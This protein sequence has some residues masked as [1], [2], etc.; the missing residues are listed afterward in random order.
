MRIVTRLALM[1]VLLFVAAAYIEAGELTVTNFIDYGAPTRVGEKRGALT[2]YDV[3]QS[4]LLVMLVQDFYKNGVRVSVLLVN[5]DTGKTE[6]YWFPN[7]ETPSGDP[8]SLLI[9]SKNRLYFTP[10]STL[11]EF[12]IPTR[13]FTYSGPMPGTAMS[14]TEAEDGTIFIA[15]YPT[16][17]LV[18]FDPDTQTIVRYGRLDPKE[19]YPYSMAIDDKGWIYSGLGTTR[20]NLVAFNIH[21]GTL[22]QLA[23]ESE[24]STGHGHVKVGKNN[25]IY[26][27]GSDSGL[28]YEL[29][30]GEKVKPAYV[31]PQTKENTLKWSEVATSW[32][33]GTRLLAL[34][35]MD[36]WA[37][38]MEPRTI[39]K[40]IDFAYDAE[41]GRITSIVA[42]PDGKIYGNTAHPMRFFMFDPETNALED[43]GS[44]PGVGNFPEFVVQDK[45]IVGGS[46][47]NGALYVYDTEKT[48]NLNQG[49]PKTV[50]S[51][52]KDIARPRA[53]VAHTDGEHIVLGG[54][55]GYGLTGGGLGIYNIN[56]G[57]S[58]LITHDNLIPYQST[59]GLRVLPS[60]DVVGVTSIK[61]PGGGYVYAEQAELYILDWETRTVSFSIKPLER[62]AFGRAVPGPGEI[63][64]LEV[65]PDGLVYGIGENGYLFV[66]DPV[67]KEIIHRRS[68][69]EYGAP[70]QR[71]TL[72]LGPDAHVYALMQ[73]ALIH[74]NPQTF[75]PTKVADLPVPATATPYL[76]GNRLYFASQTHLWSCDFVQR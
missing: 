38:V 51:Y 76:V 67:K 41:G 22:R 3:D 70:M 36:K 25:V 16:A 47:A 40:R 46:Y 26:G 49:H 69:S 33:D 8:F 44:V 71:G 37:A 27:K 48:W 55:A 15:T 6:Q 57:V 7:K 74:I 35:F 13:R 54:F 17:D 21:T 32:S 14:F 72:F 24:R 39:G 43:W 18:S 65:A 19:Q 34:E 10:G 30:D 60:G 4:R 9:S 11:A 12:D 31:L 63:A 52:A 5:I 1:L 2:T 42:G 68:L 20:S 58:Q 23:A 62:S 53:I 45:Y 50:A 56:T 64:G 73:K 75:V 61:A 59:V 66:F 29:Y 28:W